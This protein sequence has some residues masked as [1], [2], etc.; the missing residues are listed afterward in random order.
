MKNA[1]I[2]DL[3]G[4]LQDDSWR[5]HLI[6]TTEDKYSAYHDECCHDLP[7]DTSVFRL[8][9]HRS[10]SEQIIFFTGRPIA[11]LEQTKKYIKEVLMISDAETYLL[12]MRA[13]GDTRS[14][15]EIKKSMLNMVK[16]TFPD[17]KF[18]RA[19]DDRQEVVYMYL[20]EGLN[21]YVMDIDGIREAPR[22]RATSFEHKVTPPPSKGA[23]RTD[24]SDVAAA[25]R[26]MADTFEERNALYGDSGVKVGKVM[27]V[28]FPNGYACRSDGDHRMMDH[29]NR[30]IAKLVRFVNS[31]LTHK[32]SIHDLAVYAAMCEVVAAEHNIDVH[33]LE[34]EE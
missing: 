3:D 13:D 4:C 26:K 34:C 22:P 23:E 12:C 18:T 19:Y 6:G 32:D 15:P 25:L 27:A 31:G 20:E 2:F 7:I 30:V 1:A 28:L 5:R 14:S 29:F 11:Y 10:A 9:A 24:Y 17:M 8:S 16:E 33:P 21:A